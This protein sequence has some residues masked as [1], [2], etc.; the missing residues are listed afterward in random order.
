MKDPHTVIQTLLVTEKGTR[1]QGQ[2]QYLF[3]VAREANKIEI[4]RAVES[5]FNV[6]VASVNTMHVR[7]KAKRGGR[8]F[9]PGRTS[10]WKKAVVTLK[11]GDKIELA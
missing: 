9:Q 11:P 1:L 4:R 2:N 6:R 7:G 10:S 5:L 8:R 3:R